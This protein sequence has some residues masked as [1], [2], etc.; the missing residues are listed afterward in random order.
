M[1][2]AHFYLKNIFWQLIWTDNALSWFPNQKL[3]G[4]DRHINFSPS[5]PPFP[6]P[7][8]NAFY[9]FL[10]ILLGIFCASVNHPMTYLLPIKKNVITHYMLSFVFCF[11][12]SGAYLRKL[13]IW[14]SEAQPH[15]ILQLPS[16]PS[17]DGGHSLWNWSCNGGNFDDIQ[18]FAILNNAAT[19]NFINTSF[20]L[21]VI[22]LVR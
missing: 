5:L 19:N 22:A 21:S 12:H 2:R 17:W 18:H 15:S 13:S 3:I 4:N 9:C 14:V 11:F 6:L 10:C 16:F 8:G 20:H 7:T 1:E